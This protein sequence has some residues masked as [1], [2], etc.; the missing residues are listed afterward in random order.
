M[1]LIK[2]MKRQILQIIHLHNLKII[3]KMNNLKIKNNN[4]NYF[5]KK[6]K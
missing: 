2:K 3:K 1:K 6:S 5:K 4:L